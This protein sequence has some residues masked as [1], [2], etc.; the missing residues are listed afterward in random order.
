MNEYTYL[1]GHI[2]P[3]TAYIVNDYPWGFRLRTTIRYWIESKAA[4]NGGQRFASQTINP[5]TGKWCAP[6][7]STYSPIIIMYLDEKKHVH[8]C[9]LHHNCEDEYID[10]FVKTHIA[11][12][13]EFQK[14]QLRQI[15]AF[16]E[17]MKHVSFEI[18]ACPIGP[19][20]LL[21]Q[22]PEDVEKRR[23][24]IELQDQRKKEQQEIGAKI[25]MAINCEYQKNKKTIL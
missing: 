20:S 8:T 21:S 19:V 7:Y 2:S 4:K 18:K 17:V 24:I 6:K 10:Q 22:D 1:Y 11:N 12:M 5:K 14:D 25:N 16:K 3:E 15:L 13:T 23:K 9:G